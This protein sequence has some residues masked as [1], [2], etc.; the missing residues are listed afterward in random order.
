VSTGSRISGAE[1]VELTAGS[2]AYVHM[3]STEVRNRALLLDDLD[4]YAAYVDTLARDG[5]AA[6]R[7]HGRP[8]HS[9]A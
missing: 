1:L 3:T 7:S 2:Y 6:G 8:I 5:H 4:G 9:H